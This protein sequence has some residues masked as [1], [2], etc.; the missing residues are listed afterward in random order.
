MTAKI[1]VPIKPAVKSFGFMGSAIAAGSTVF[2]GLQVALQTPGGLAAF[3]GNL[4][5]KYGPIALLVIGIGGS[6]F[7]NIRRPDVFLRPG[8]LREATQEAANA[9]MKELTIAEMAQTAQQGFEAVT[10]PPDERIDK[11]VN[12]AVDLQERMSRMEVA[13]TAQQFPPLADYP[14]RTDLPTEPRQR[15]QMEVPPVQWEPDVDSEGAIIQGY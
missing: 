14:D 12:L 6:L 5:D 9:A 4:Q 13:T 1:E 11:L 3:C 10:A 7:G 2:L 15:A 8:K